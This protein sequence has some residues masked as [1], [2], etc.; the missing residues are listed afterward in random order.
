[1]NLANS[2]YQIRLPLC[3]KVQGMGILTLRDTLSSSKIQQLLQACG[4]KI[5]IGDLKAVFKELGFNWNGP[6]CSIQK[7]VQKL[8]EYLNPGAVYGA[9]DE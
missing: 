4:L 2:I 9:R 6:S 5:A 7:L 1:M 3:E 8:K